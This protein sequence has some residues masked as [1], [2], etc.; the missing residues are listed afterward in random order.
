MIYIY[1]YKHMQKKKKIPIFFNEF[2]IY[3]IEG[4][5]IG[6][7]V[8]LYFDMNVKRKQGLLI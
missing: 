6:I 5:T 4:V 1:I 8:M 7:R 3:K 2:D